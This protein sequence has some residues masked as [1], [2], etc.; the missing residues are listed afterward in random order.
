MRR[1]LIALTIAATL[2]IAASVASSGTYQPPGDA[3]EVQGGRWLLAGRMFQRANL[4]AHPHLIIVL[5]GDA[6]HGPPKYQYVFAQRAATA[7][8]DA[9]VIA[10]LRP[11]YSD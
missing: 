11:G 5:H 9:M 7:L 3:V 4:S 2:A 1:R 6:P 8:D 10:L